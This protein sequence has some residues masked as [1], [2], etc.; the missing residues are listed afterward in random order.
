MW[1]AIQLYFHR[2]K[3]RRKSFREGRTKNIFTLEHD[4]EG[5]KV[6]WLTIENESGTTEIVWSDVGQILA[7][8]RDCFAYDKICLAIG[9]N[10]DTAFEINE[11]MD[12]WEELIKKLP[13]YLPGCK[14]ME[15]WWLDI[16][17]PAFEL[18]LTTIYQRNAKRDDRVK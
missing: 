3:E 16:Q 6:S 5:L 1:R 10:D 7:F 17:T 13:D 15:E 12:G 14:A 9:L 18:N 11:N 4:L 8:K 2:M